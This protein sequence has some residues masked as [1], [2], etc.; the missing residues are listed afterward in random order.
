MNKG[1]NEVIG[2]SWGTPKTPK[3][4]GN[5]GNHRGEED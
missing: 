2:N 1:T 4:L 5:E 3:F